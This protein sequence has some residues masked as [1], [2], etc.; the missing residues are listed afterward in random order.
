M[1]RRKFLY[2]SGLLAAGA[3]AAFS[4]VGCQNDAPASEEKQEA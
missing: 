4:W 2:Q 1:N 3:L